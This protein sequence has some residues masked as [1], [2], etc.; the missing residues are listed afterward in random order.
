M[1]TQ[2]P[3]THTPCR[4]S[5]LF[6][7]VFPVSPSVSQGSAEDSKM[8]QEAL[9][10]LR[11]PELPPLKDHLFCCL[12]MF[13]VCCRM[14]KAGLLRPS[15]V[16]WMS[17]GTMSHGKSLT[18]RISVSPNPESACILSDI[19][20][21]DVPEKYYLSQTQMQRLLS[22]SL[23]AQRAI[24]STRTRESA[25]LSQAMPEVRRKNRTL[26]C[27]TAYQ[28]DTKSGFQLA[29]PGDSI[30]LAYPTMNTRRGRVGE[31]IAHTVTPGNT[32]G[33]FFIDMN[34]D[35]KLTEV[36]RCI[37]A[38]QDSGISKRRG[39]H[40]AVFIEDE[41]RAVVTPDKKTIRQQGR[42]IKEPN[43]PMF[44]LT[45]QDRH[46]ILRYGRVRK[47]TPRECWRLQGFTDEQFNKAAATGL[48]DGR[49]YKMAGNAV[50]VPVVSAVGAVIKRIYQEQIQKG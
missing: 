17:W 33:Y 1:Q 19:L 41:P 4:I 9:S 39:E 27:S 3:L 40:S 43:E 15:S 18:A 21:K 32:Q 14:T 28:V 2:E 42:W 45:V 44:T 46:G 10:F 24:G 38:R 31:K 48:S 8:T 5:T 34:Y 25:L 35:P 20:E 12:K 13:P 11:S 47:L 50:S 23:E 16:R 22:N 29:H 49:L 36:A 26:R 30:D 37:T 7:A 6:A